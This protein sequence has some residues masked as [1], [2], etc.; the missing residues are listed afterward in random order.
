MNTGMGNG[1]GTSTLVKSGNTLKEMGHEIIFI[2]SSKNQHTWTPLKPKHLIIKKESHI[3]DADI[4]I[5]TG[6]GSWKKTIVLPDRCGKKFIWVRGYELWQASEQKLV[7][8][9]SNKKLT[10]IVNSIGLQ[11]KLLKFKIKSHIIRPGNNLDDFKFLNLRN[12]NKIILGGLYHT[13]HKTKRSDWILKATRILKK[14]Y[15]N[16]ELHMF[17]IDQDPRNPLIDNYLCNPSLNKKNIFFNKIDI[18]LSPTELE[19]LHIVPQEAMLTRCPI[20][21]TNAELAGVEDYLLNNYNGLIADNNFDSFFDNID[22]LVKN[23]KRRIE[24]SLP[25]RRTIEYLGDRK[26]NMKKFIKLMKFYLN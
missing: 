18:F 1:G 22:Y 17:G 20:I 13:K 21:A 2:D 15:N 19:G 25:T 16:I 8:I 24:L 10:I 26:C 3:P 23:K 11:K 5:G 14:K 12:S 7:K 6:F 4:I 9:L